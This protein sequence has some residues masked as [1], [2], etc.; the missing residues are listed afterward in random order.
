MSPEL[1]VVTLAGVVAERTDPFCL[2]GTRAHGIASGG[3][4]IRRAAVATSLAA[5]QSWERQ[6][7]EVYG[8]ARV[9][10]IGSVSLVWW[11]DGGFEALELQPGEERVL[12]GR[13]VGY[14]ARSGPYPR[15]VGSPPPPEYA[16][17]VLAGPDLDRFPGDA[18]RR[19]VTQ[20]WRVDPTSDRVGTRL[21]GDALPVL[22]TGRMPS[23]PM[24][25]GA[26]QVPGGG[27]PIVLGPDHPVTGG[28]PVLAVLPGYSCDDLARHAPGTVVTF[29]LVDRATALERYRGW[30][31]EVTG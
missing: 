1:R 30:K 7:L 12:A 10:A 18:M 24:C 29:R 17:D 21:A 11:V 13:P 28:Y 25:R 26:V 9:E 16:L 5:G 22:G 2:C 23:G 19:L 15:S 14:L 27:L 20:L 8:T 31:A 6:C 3:P 4:L